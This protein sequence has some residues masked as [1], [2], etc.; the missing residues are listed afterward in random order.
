M[1]K[2]YDCDM[3][4]GRP[5]NCC[6]V[7]LDWWT[8]FQRTRLQ[9]IRN[10]SCSSKRLQEDIKTQSHSYMNIESLPILPNSSYDHRGGW[11]LKVPLACQL[12]SISIE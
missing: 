4:K 12:I 9:I 3:E 11:G 8:T 7:Q 2:H 5:K 6:M 1:I 10:F